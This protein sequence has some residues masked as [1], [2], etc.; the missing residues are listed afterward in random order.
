MRCFLVVEV[1]RLVD[2]PA[3][4]GL[5]VGK[6]QAPFVLADAVAPFSQRVQVAIV[7]A[8][9]RATQLDLVQSG[10]APGGVPA[11]MEVVAADASGQRIGDQAQVHRALAGGQASEDMD[12]HA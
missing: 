7:A 4:L 10:P 8:G 5:V 3:G 11:Q 2:E 1:G 9:H 6:Y 12:S